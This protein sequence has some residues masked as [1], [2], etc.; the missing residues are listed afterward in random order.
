MFKQDFHPRHWR[1]HH[2]CP[3][4][5]RHWYAL[6]QNHSH[7][8]RVL[9][10]RGR[11][12]WRCCLHRRRSSRGTVK[13]RESVE[14]LLVEMPRYGIKNSLCIRGTATQ[15]GIDEPG[16]FSSYSC[17]ASNA[18]VSPFPCMSSASSVVVMNPSSNSESCATNQKWSTRH[19]WGLYHNKL[20]FAILKEP[21]QGSF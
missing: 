13:V 19:L 9:S 5:H 14:E 10:R 7:C 17:E 18:T 21:D 20:L 1:L 16:H 8:R 3:G 15:T 12:K 2:C 4:H 11:S 6:H